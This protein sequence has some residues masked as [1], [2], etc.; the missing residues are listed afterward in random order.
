MDTVT[1]TRYV[2]C[3]YVLYLTTT[4]VATG[5]Q[6]S[7]LRHAVRI[8]ALVAAEGDRGHLPRFGV[9]DHHY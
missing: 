5:T 1:N 8:A 3:R 7:S 6:A 9:A 2:Q 4:R